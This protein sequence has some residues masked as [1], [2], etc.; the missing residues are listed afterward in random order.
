MT[1][2]R[3]EWSDNL[4]LRIEQQERSSL[5][6]YREAAAVGVVAEKLLTDRD[7]WNRFVQMIQGAIDRVQA[8]KVIAQD[9]LSDPHVWQHEHL[10]KLKSDILSADQVIAFGEMIIQLPKALQEGADKAQA[11]I[12]KYEQANDQGP[13]TQNP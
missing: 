13:A 5:P 12:N 7:H 1:Y 4:K 2:D 8:R 11:I 3:K 9:R 6:A 10:V